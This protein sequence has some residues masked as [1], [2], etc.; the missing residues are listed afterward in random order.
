[1]ICW[2]RWETPFSLN[3]RTNVSIRRLEFMGQGSALKVEDIP[4]QLVTLLVYPLV[5]SHW[6]Q[7]FLQLWL[8]SVGPLIIVNF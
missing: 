6:N 8:C 1:M 5:S 7:N 3:A 4:C 2:R